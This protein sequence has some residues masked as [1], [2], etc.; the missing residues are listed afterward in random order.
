MNIDHVL[1]TLEDY[2]WDTVRD[3]PLPKNEMEVL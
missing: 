2:Y 1:L 3:I